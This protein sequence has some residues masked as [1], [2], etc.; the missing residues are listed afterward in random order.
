LSGGI[1]VFLAWRM[2]MKTSDTSFPPTGHAS[3][4]ADTA[5]APITFVAQLRGID[6]GGASDGRPWPE[7]QLAPGRRIALADL[8]CALVGLRTVHDILLAAERARQDGGP[9]QDVGERI[10]EGLMQACRALA[11]YA[12]LNVRPC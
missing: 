10:V 8:D 12:S 11:M 3:A 2:P 6:S 5:G 7:R 9:D 1:T 4:N